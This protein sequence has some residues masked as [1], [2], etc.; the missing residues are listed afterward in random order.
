MIPRQEIDR[1]GRLI[2]GSHATP[3]EAGMAPYMPPPPSAAQMYMPQQG[4]QQGPMVNPGNPGFSAVEK[5]GDPIDAP[6][7]AFNMPADTPSCLSV[8]EHIASC[9]ICSKFYNN[10]KTIYIIAI[11]V[12]ALVCILLLKRVLDV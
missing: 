8:A 1:V 10:D 2:R 7:S 6:K 11:V 12:L 9:P 4:P 3:A 5:Y